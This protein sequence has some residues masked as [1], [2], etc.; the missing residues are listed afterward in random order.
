[1]NPMP[2]IIPLLKQLRLS[3]IL[4]SLESRNRQ[5]I[6]EKLS[7]MDFLATIVTDEIA[8]RT[9]KRLASAFRRANFRSQKTLEEFDFT[10]NPNINRALITDLASGRFIEEKVCTLI[11]GPCGTGKS[12]IAQAL[13]HCA[14]RAGYDVLFTTVSKM[15]AQLNAARAHNGF[16]RHFAKLTA[17]DLLII[18]D[19]GLK[20]LQGSQDEDFHDVIA[21]RY[22][23]KSAIVTSNLDIPEWTEAF[24]NRIL[25]AAT[26]DRLLHGAYKVL[27]DG[28]SYRTTQLAP[29]PLKAISEKSEKTTE[30]K[31]PK[32]GENP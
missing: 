2:E 18:D 1:M 29:K 30:K 10:F 28:K 20:P 32:G 16:D 23:R 5:A 17:V 27:L 24:P 8:R 12:H 15:L 7:Y 22:E 3:G 25:G 21:E 11:V 13:G 6:E 14:I 31:S 9:Q 26:I 4:D 19:F